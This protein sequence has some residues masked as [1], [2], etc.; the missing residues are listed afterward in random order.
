MTSEEIVAFAAKNDWSKIDRHIDEKDRG[1]FKSVYKKAIPFIRPS[2]TTYRRNLEYT[3][4]YYDDPF[5]FATDNLLTF[6]LA[7][8]VNRNIF[9]Y[10]TMRDTFQRLFE[11]GL[12]SNFSPYLIF[13]SNSSNIE[14]HEKN[15]KNIQ[16]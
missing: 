15:K 6:Q 12:L 14:P 1:L 9:F 4:N 5:K 13:I 8:G 16:L 10:E 2:E 3:I 7:F 11:F